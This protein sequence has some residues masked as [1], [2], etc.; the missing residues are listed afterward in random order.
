MAKSQRDIQ[1]NQ[2]QLEGE[3][4]MAPSKDDGL[5]FKLEEEDIDLTIQPAASASDQ[6]WEEIARLEE[7]VDNIELTPTKEDSD[8]PTVEQKKNTMTNSDY[9]EFEQIEEEAPIPDDPFQ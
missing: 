1:S 5:D 6:E 8:S 9:E 4:E 7:Q 2:R 3:S